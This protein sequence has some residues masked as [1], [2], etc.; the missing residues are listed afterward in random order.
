MPDNKKILL[1]YITHNSGHHRASLAIE[2]ALKTISPSVETL[3]INA[4]GYT[5]PILEKVINR[6][7]MTVI[8]GK[9]AVWEYLYDNPK[10]LKSVQGL[11]DA[12]HRF[13]SKKLKVL[14]EDFKP[15]VCLCTQ[16]FPCGMIADYKKN[17]HL[18]LP[19]FG[20]LT[21]NAPHSYWIFEEVDYYIT[22]SETSKEHFVKNGVA[23]DKI[24]T[25]GIPIDP[26]FNSHGNRAEIYR[27]MDFDTE[28]PVVLIMGGSQGLGPVENIADVLE[29]IA[30]PFQLVVIC[31][32][33]R[34]LKRKLEKKKARYKKRLSVLGHVENVNELMEIASI[35]V[36]KPGGLTTAEAL[37]K[38]LP[39]IIVHPIPGQELKNT[40]FLLNKGV[41]VRAEDAEDIAAL[42]QELLIS[43][44]KLNE[45]MKHTSLLKK[46][47]SAM[48]IA[49][50]V[51][52][53]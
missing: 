25:F 2:N 18:K 37:A 5:N 14:L 21:D 32:I 31:G 9:P 17:L 15:D 28:W 22:P 50:L 30:A 49:N 42:V 19:L 34:K 40:E 26:K 39:M 47:N 43:K 52:S 45:M 41:A 13:N 51:M 11:R 35:V 1:M 27:K 12:I 24:R 53:L 46:P 7:Y 16:A 6:T 3:N 29:G 10:V 48:D 23:L 20:V 4:F 8:K 36:T 33:N 44:T 38:D